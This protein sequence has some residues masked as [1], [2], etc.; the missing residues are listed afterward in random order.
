MRESAVSVPSNIAEGSQRVSGR[1][2]SQFLHI[3]K[4]S[5]AELETQLVIALR[6]GYCTAQEGEYLLLKI[7]E[8]S[9]MLRA[10]IISLRTTH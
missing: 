4:G 5:L 9:K 10:L 1:D 7:L 6:I 8:L 2:F 3:A